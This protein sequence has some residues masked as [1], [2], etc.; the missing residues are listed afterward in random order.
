M[1]SCLLIFDSVFMFKSSSSTVDEIDQ[2]AR[3]CVVTIGPRSLGPNFCKFVSSRVIA[4]PMMSRTNER[5]R[6]KEETF[7]SRRGI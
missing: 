6:I 2:T 5:K 1:I 3:V 7:E 4:G